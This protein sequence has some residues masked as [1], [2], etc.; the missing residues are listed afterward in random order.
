MINMFN[1]AKPICVS[2]TSR[3]QG[4]FSFFGEFRLRSDCNSGTQLS[5]NEMKGCIAV[6]LPTLEF[7]ESITEHVTLSS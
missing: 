6:P 5:K 2:L 3:V 4:V 1:P 7:A